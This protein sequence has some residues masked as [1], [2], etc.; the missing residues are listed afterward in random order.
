MICNYCKKEGHIM[1]INDKNTGDVIYVCPVL[2]EKRKREKQQKYNNRVTKNFN[3]T[4]EQLKNLPCDQLNMVKNDRFLK[5]IRIGE[6][7]YFK[8]EAIKM[9]KMW[10]S[11]VINKLKSMS[12]GKKG[13]KGKKVKN[14]N[15]EIPDDMK[16]MYSL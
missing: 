3:K 13:K 2:K 15:N 1:K 8:N 7:V 4:I 16:H 9:I 6:S 12:K 14:Y 11:G 5:V 10:Y